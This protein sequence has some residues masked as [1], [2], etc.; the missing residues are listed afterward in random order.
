MLLDFQ[1]LSGVRNGQGGSD[2]VL[3]VFFVPVSKPKTTKCP[4]SVWQIYQAH[5]KLTA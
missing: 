5:S 4:H 3:P 1:R 2:V